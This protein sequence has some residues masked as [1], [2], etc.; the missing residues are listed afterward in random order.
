MPEVKTKS[1]YDSIPEERKI[2][3]MRES[4]KR[5]LQSIAQ[6]VFGLEHYPEF[7]MCRL[8]L[9]P[10]VVFRSCLI[11]SKVMLSRMIYGLSPE[12]PATTS[13]CSR[14]HPL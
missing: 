8:P 5:N 10:A 11:S 2:E 6:A 4:C 1:P 9:V 7:R 13:A 14:K 12:R 3:L